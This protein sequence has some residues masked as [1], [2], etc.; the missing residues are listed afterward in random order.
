M[1]FIWILNKTYIIFFFIF[2]YLLSNCIFFFN[3]P[4]LR[5]S[6]KLSR[7]AF[8]LVVVCYCCYLC[9]CCCCCFLFIYIQVSFSQKFLFKKKILLAKKE[10][11]LNKWKIKETNSN[12]WLINEVC[13]LQEVSFKFYPIL[14]R[15]KMTTIFKYFVHLF[16]LN[17]LKII[18]QWVTAL[19]LFFFDPVEFILLF[20]TILK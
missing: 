19:D 18:S 8:R 17:E 11:L 9:C 3:F 2:Q 6:V 7:V 12:K 1:Q 20:Q 5:K 10:S 16:Q 15:K 13:L 4:S 14:K